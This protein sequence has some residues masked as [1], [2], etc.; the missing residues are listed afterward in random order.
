MEAMH[1]PG[2]WRWEI[3]E[4]HKSINLCGGRP[5]YD[6]TVMDFQRWGMQGAQIRLRDTSQEG[7]NLMYNTSHWA[8]EVKRREHHAGWFKSLNHPDA[9][10]IQSAPDLLDAT[11]KAVASLLIDQDIDAALSHLQ[12][13]IKKATGQTDIDNRR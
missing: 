7:R 3:N 8:K 11:K 4:R 13:A 6:L 12:E 2:P 1:T 9:V 5:L 10:L